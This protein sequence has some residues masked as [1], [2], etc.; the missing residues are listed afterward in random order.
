MGLFVLAIMMKA[1]PDDECISV[2]GVW[3]VVLVVLFVFGVVIGG[4]LIDV[5]S[6]CMLFVI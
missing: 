3:S 5:T 6:W 2:V 4:L 1:F